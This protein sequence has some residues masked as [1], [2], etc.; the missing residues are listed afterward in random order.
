M[1]FSFEFFFFYHSTKVTV[2][3]CLK[4]LPKMKAGFSENSCIFLKIRNQKSK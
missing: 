1:W 3:N 4:T 2:E